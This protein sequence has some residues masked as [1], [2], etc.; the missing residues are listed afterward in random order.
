MSW[1]GGGEIN[2]TPG[3]E[4]RT[5]AMTAS[6]LW[7]GSCPPSPGLAPWAIL[8]WMSSALT[9]YSAVPPKRAEARGGHRLDRRA[10]RVAV[11]V[12]REA[13]RVLA[14]FAGVRLAADAVHRHRE[15]LV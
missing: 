6:T 15:V 9:R 2:V 11:G 7:P 14:A 10:G 3:I 4:W 1:C 5:R 13:R 12:D 8:I